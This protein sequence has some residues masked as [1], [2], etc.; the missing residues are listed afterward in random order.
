MD[1]LGLDPD[2]VD[3]LEMYNTIPT[4]LMEKCAAL[5]VRPDTVKNL[6][7]A[8]QGQWHPLSKFF[9]FLLVM[10]NYSSLNS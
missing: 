8:M 1:S 5:S 10:A 7:Q 4:V 3:N 6:I 2:S 9:Y